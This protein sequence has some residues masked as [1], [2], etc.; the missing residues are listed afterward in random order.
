MFRMISSILLLSAPCIFTC[1]VANA[2]CQMVVD[3]KKTPF[4]GS[5]PPSMM[6]E[7]KSMLK[8]DKQFPD[9]NVVERIF[10]GEIVTCS[11][12]SDQYIVC[13]D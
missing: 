3:G 5:V 7:K 2:D 8:L 12:C 1:A 10:K 4:D 11:D 6:V 9:A 13:N